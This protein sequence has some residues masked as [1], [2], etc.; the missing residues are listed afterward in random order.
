MSSN[1][2][3]VTNRRRTSSAHVPIKDPQSGTNSAMP[4]QRSPKRRLPGPSFPPD[5]RSGLVPSD[6]RGIRGTEARNDGKS[7]AQRISTHQQG[8]RRLCRGRV[9]PPPRDA[10]A[11][12]T[13]QP[14]QGPCAA[15]HSPA[16]DPTAEEAADRL[17]DSKVDTM[18]TCNLSASWPHLGSTAAHPGTSEGASWPT[19]CL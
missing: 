7:A 17:D 15:A 6:A 18:G 8:R 16:T 14:T 11:T 4:C 5:G 1:R 12:R 2:R 10:C 3:T 13:G 9:Y 19:L